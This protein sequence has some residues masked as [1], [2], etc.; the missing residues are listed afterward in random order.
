M[1][2]RPP[3]STLFPYTTLFRSLGVD[4]FRY[5]LATFVLGSFVAGLARV[6]FAHFRQGLHSSDFGLEPMVLLV[7]FTVIGGTG[8]VWGAG[9]GNLLIAVRSGVLRE[10]HPYSV[11]VRSE[12]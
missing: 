6:F 5:K 10:L 4:V 11:L 12:E 9:G 3:R 8:R 2:R 1:I 7:V